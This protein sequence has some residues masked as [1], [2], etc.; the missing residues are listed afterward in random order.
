MYVL[1]ALM[2]AA[3]FSSET[4]DD[5]PQPCSITEIYINIVR[6]CL[7]T[8]SN[9]PK[10]QLNCFIK[11][12]SEELLSLAEAAFNATEGKTVNLTELTC[13]DSCVLS[14]LKPLVIK[15]EP[16]ETITMYAFLHYT[17]QEFFAALWLLKNPDKIKDVFQ[18]CFT[19]E[20]KHMK[21]LIP[22]MC[23]LLTEKNPSFMKFLIP[24]EVLKKTSNWFF[25]EL[26]TTF[27]SSL[28]YQDQADID[29]SG[30]GVDILFLCQCFYESQCPEACAYF[31]FHNFTAQLLS[32]G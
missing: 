27:F 20:K 15:V 8:I 11:S 22:F 31:H 9:K 19:E 25:E 32:Q 21:R 14:F 24:V 4:T 10:K 6:F 1:Y 2:V 17:M 12:K 29:D 3:C 18:Q 13:E 7:Q 30:P 26:T 23:R 16:T 5:S 28:C